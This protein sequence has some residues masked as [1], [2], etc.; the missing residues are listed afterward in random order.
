MR[1]LEP[2][3]IVRDTKFCSHIKDV[4]KICGQLGAN[5]KDKETRRL[6]DKGTGSNREKGSFE[7]RK[8]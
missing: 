1:R 3:T 4:S 8:L 7:V 5:N 2:L 6:G